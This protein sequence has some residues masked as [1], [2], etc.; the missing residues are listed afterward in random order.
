MEEQL[1]GLLRHE[2]L[3]AQ[4]AEL[5]GL[6]ALALASVGLYGVTAYSAVRRT[7]EIGIRTALGATRSTVIRLILGGALQQMG[8]ALIIGIAAAL[9]AGRVLADLLYGVKTY[10]PLFWRQPR[11][12]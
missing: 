9:G 1:R 6:L 8:I 2:W 4:L 10:D 12:C 3:I 5:F 11:L 7:S